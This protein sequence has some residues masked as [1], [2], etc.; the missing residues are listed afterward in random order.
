VRAQGDEAHEIAQ[1]K[2]LAKVIQHKPEEN[3]TVDKTVIVKNTPEALELFGITAAL[4][5]PPIKDVNVTKAQVEEITSTTT[6][7][8]TTSSDDLTIETL[9][10][11]NEEQLNLTEVTTGI[12]FI[13]QFHHYH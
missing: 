11:S 8:T 6:T 7:T 12:E 5:P 9:T 10:Q 3:S 4:K 1:R 2:S 13:L